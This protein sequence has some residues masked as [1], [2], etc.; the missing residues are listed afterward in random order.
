MRTDS[1]EKLAVRAKPRKSEHVGIWLAV[2]EQQVR[3]DV[4]FPVA[5]PIADQVMVT[6]FSIERL[7]SHKR[8]ENA[9]ELTIKCGPMLPFGFALVIAFER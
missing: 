5:C 3:L 6:A 1:A 8:H 4:A 7:V 2:D 9:L